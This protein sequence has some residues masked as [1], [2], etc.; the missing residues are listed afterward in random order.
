M[1]H[2]EMAQLNLM[3]GPAEA[4]C[5]APLGNLQAVSKQS[6]P[7]WN[8]A[9]KKESIP[10]GIIS[11]IFL[12]PMGFARRGVAVRSV[13]PRGPGPSPKEK[14]VSLRLQA[15]APHCCSWPF[16]V[17]Q[18]QK[19]NNDG[20]LPPKGMEKNRRWAAKGRVR[21]PLAPGLLKPLGLPGVR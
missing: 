1:V 21:R 2:V 7:R 10:L 13:G 8:L 15:G 5:S 4:H 18:P 19:A 16:S 6:R 3:T 12:N 9:S 11:K 14:L 20:N 17:P